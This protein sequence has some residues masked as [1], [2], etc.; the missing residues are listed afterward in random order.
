[1]HPQARRHHGG[2]V[3][4]QPAV[5]AGQPVPDLHAALALLW[6]GHA[7][8]VG[9]GPG[10]VLLQ[11]H[12]RPHRHPHPRHHGGGAQRPA[13]GDDSGD[14]ATV[15]AGHHL[16]HRLHA[17][18]PAQGH[19]LR[20]ARGHVLQYKRHAPAAA[21]PL[22]PR[23]LQQVAVGVRRGRGRRLRGLPLGLRQHHHH[24]PLRA[25]G[26]GVDLLLHDAAARLLLRVPRLRL[27]RHR[28]LGQDVRAEPC[29]DEHVPGPL[30]RLPGLRPAHRRGK[31]PRRLRRVR[32]G[33]RV[34]QVRLGGPAAAG[35]RAAGPHAV[36][37]GVGGH[38]VGARRHRGGR[39]AALQVHKL[40]RLQPR[41][42]VR[43]V[44][45][46]VRRGGQVH[47]RAGQADLR[48][49]P[50]R[51]GL[52]RHPRRDLLR[53]RRGI[54]HVPR[55]AVRLRGGR[56]RERAA[57]PAGAGG[58][59]RGLPPHPRAARH[60]G[61]LPRQAA[62]RRRLPRPPPPYPRP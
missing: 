2:G 19:L 30:R 62:L 20:R 42:A 58:V 61:P 35:L 12:P 8:G 46:D 4:R 41:Q 36:Q 53:R 18:Q 54:R 38:L 14:G 26:D 25:Q 10:L 27:H 56:G 22:H 11:L 57:G 39:A 51:Q 7:R 17:L 50:R 52:Q 59:V 55:A 44:P 37:A 48:H 47:D 3:A 6:R 45:H 29:D 24:H 60:A 5:R 9:H 21:R 49:L 16:P 13:H 33:Q 40:P 43:L 15:P 31:R 32:Q 1:M 23:R 28:H 34:R